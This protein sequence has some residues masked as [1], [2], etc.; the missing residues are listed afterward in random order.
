M[1]YNENISIFHNSIKTFTKLPYWK[2]KN[3][4]I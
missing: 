3:K 2:F 4:K 1:S